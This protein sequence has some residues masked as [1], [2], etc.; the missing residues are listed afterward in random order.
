MSGKVKYALRIYA[1]DDAKILHTV[2]DFVTG[3]SS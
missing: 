2:H 1:A 3:K